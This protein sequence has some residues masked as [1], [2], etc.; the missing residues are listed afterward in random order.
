MQ[1]VPFKDDAKLPAHLSVA[2][3]SKFNSDLTAHAGAGFPVISIKGKVFAIVRE[4]E[5]KIIPNPKD[6]ESPAG[7][8]DVVI[9]KANKQTSKVFYIK[10][11]NETEEGKKPDCFSNDGVKPDEASEA[12]QSES[13]AVCKHNVWGSKVSTDGKGGKG[14]ACQDAVRMAV[15]T[16]GAI[17]DPY[18]IRVPPAS[19][20]ALGELG[21]QLAKRKVPYNGIVT[22]ISFDQEEATPKLTFKPVGFLDEE[23]YKQ[24]KEV[25]A[26]DVV[27]SILG[28]IG[29]SA[30]VVEVEKPAVVATTKTVTQEEVKAAVAA[31]AAAAKPKAEPA[32]AAAGDFAVDLAGLTFDD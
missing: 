1:I 12:K 7:N 21:S 24:V 2:E 16:P 5:R 15:A 31:A 6:P 8:I 9:I 30:P 22:K 25:A 29:Q 26:G 23:T 11:F 17:N 3:A 18:L 20:R 13:C 32:K 28:V 14:K 19:I 4:G 10:G 27:S